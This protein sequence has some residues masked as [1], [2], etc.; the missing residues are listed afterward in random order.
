MHIDCTYKYDFTIVGVDGGNSLES[1]DPHKK[2]ITGGD[3][4]QLSLTPH[5]LLS[6]SSITILPSLLYPTL[7]YSVL[8]VMLLLDYQNAL[9]QSLLTERFSG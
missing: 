6:S 5:L 8:P 2:N 7:F 4:D 9:I 3:R 1:T